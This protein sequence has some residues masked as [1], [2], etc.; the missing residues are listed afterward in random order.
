VRLKQGDGTF[1][2]LTIASIAYGVSQFAGLLNTTAGINI[3]WLV[4]WEGFMIFNFLLSLRAYK[5]AQLMEPGVDRDEKY[6]KSL[7]AS[8]SYGLGGILNGINAVYLAVH[9]QSFD[10]VDKT[11]F[12]FV[13]IALIFVLAWYRKALLCPMALACYAILCKAVPQLFM[14]WRVGPMGIDPAN[15]LAILAIGHLL[16][17]LRLMILFRSYR[18]KQEEATKGLII[19]EG[20]NELSWLIVTMSWLWF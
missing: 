5:E 16:I 3:S 12:L 11:N 14:A 20:T 19:S 15:F 8:I 7:Q 10:W 2:V 9:L 6:R 17:I 1:I 4:L 13:G 18:A